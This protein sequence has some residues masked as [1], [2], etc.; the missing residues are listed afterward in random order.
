MFY[1]CLVHPEWMKYSYSSKNNSGIFLLDCR[2]SLI[3]TSPRPSSRALSM[4]RTGGTSMT[5][6]SSRWSQWQVVKTSLVLTRFLTTSRVSRSGELSTS[7][8]SRGR[9]SQTLSMFSTR[10]KAPSHS[11]WG[12]FAPQRRT[13]ITRK[14]NSMLLSNTAWTRA[15]WASSCSN[16]V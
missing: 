6:S 8:T 12:W 15:S 10:S 11:D 4:G 16:A 1:F 13:V 7:L 3:L 9:F 5:T 2:V 14:T